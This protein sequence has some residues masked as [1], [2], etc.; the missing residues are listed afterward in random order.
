MEENEDLV[1]FPSCEFYLIK[2]IKELIDLYLGK[3]DKTVIEM[4]W[5]VVISSVT[6]ID[7]IVRNIDHDKF[8]NIIINLYKINS[9]NINMNDLINSLE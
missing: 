6:N 3:K 9:D 2:F 7:P 8:L 5:D 4:S 1:N